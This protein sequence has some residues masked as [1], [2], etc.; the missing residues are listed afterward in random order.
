MDRLPIL[1]AERQRIGLRVV[2]CGVREKGHI[3]AKAERDLEIVWSRP[4]VLGIPA[5]GVHPERLERHRLARDVCIAHLEAIQ[6][7]GDLSAGLA[8]NRWHRRRNRPA[9]CTRGALESRGKPVVRFVPLRGDAEL[10]SCSSV[11]TEV[12]LELR[13]VV[14]EDVARRKRLE[15]N[16]TSC[17]R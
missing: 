8:G 14:R 3:V 5:V 2:K 10:R 7:T 16:D 9:C 11:N 6:R 12:V 17:C 4:S 15:P 1:V 13:R